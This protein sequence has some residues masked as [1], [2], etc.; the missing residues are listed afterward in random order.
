MGRPA[1]SY[2][3]RSS[4][5]SRDA[6]SR[7]GCRAPAPSRRRDR[8]PYGWCRAWRGGTAPCLG[9]SARW[10]ARAR[11]RRKARLRW[12]PCLFLGLRAA[13]SCCR[14]TERA[15]LAHLHCDGG[16]D[17]TVTT[18]QPVLP[19]DAAPGLPFVLSER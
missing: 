8:A 9:A 6:G 7:A 19:A 18:L 10:V 11:P 13:L 16:G 4:S 3:A 12:A 5:R 14:F 15:L 2:P 1:A 17:L